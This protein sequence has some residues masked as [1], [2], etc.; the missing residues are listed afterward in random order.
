M[1]G[2]KGVI[3]SEVSLD[4]RIRGVASLSKDTYELRV[5]VLHALLNPLRN[6]CVIHL[7][8]S[9]FIVS[10]TLSEVL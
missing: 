7:N 5:F 9:C 6:I 8:V 1:R 4:Q 2:H 10:L 3:V